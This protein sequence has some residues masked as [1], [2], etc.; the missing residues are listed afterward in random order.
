MT[1]KTDELIGDALDQALPQN[2]LLGGFVAVFLGMIGGI[3]GAYLGFMQADG[4]VTIIGAA[5]GFSTVFCLACV[6]GPPG[7]Y[8]MQ[9]A[10][11]SLT[12]PEWKRW[13]ATG[14][15]SWD[16]YVTVHRCQNAFNPREVLG[17]VPAFMKTPPSNFVTIKVGRELDQDKFL[18]RSNPVKKTCTS[19]ENIFEEV[20]HFYVTPTDESMRV[21]VW[22][23]RCF[24]TKKLGSVD[25]NLTKE[26]LEA[27]FP[28]NKGFRLLRSAMEDGD[29]DDDDEENVGYN[30]VAGTIVLS[31][32][33]GP[34]F[35][36]YA[37]ANFRSS[38]PYMHQAVY[39]SN[40]ELAQG[41]K[42]NFANYGTWALGPGR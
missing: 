42:S 30:D 15:S 29:E 11:A 18:L 14:F 37:D 17:I 23:Q 5:L 12:P 36:Q 27:G 1:D 33:P 6:C 25:I 19:L 39:K 32:K 13:R 10:G 22:D 31:F 24:S 4:I 28:Q 40:S 26:V 35:P 2:V 41:V 21:T 34:S 8:F 9:T 7:R 16:M 3:A 20:F 38:K